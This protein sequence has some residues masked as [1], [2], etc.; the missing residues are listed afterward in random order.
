MFK[1]TFFIYKK[2]IFIQQNRP[3]LMRPTKNLEKILR[4]R[5][6]LEVDGPTSLCWNI[7][8]PMLAK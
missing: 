6:F 3:L 1:N 8:F 2:Q 4:E 5:V 7:K